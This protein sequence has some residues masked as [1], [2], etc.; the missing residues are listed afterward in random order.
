MTDTPGRQLPPGV[1][2]AAAELQDWVRTAMATNRVPPVEIVEESPMTDTGKI[3]KVD[4]LE[5]ARR[6]VEAGPA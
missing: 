5:R 2:L 3:P 1:S 6:L 4:L